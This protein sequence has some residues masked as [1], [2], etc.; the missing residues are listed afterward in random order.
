MA[1]WKTLLDPSEYLGHQDFPT[2][3]KLTISRVISEI[4]EDK[5]RSA[6]MYFKHDGKE[7]TRKLRLPKSVMYGLELL[8]GYD[9]EGWTDKEVTFEAARCMSFG[10]VEPCVR[11][12]LPPAIEAK[13][14]SWMKKHKSSK[15]AYK[16]QE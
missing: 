6:F 2:P 3:K 9:F 7:L 16:V 11:P 5:K 10:A 14:F 13:I 15:S 8:L 1:H 12:V 4:G